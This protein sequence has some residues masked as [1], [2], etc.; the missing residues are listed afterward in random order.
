MGACRQRTT[1]WSSAGAR[2]RN[3]SVVFQ[4]GI[5]PLA[6]D[7][8]VTEYDV[9]VFDGTSTTLVMK[10]VNEATWMPSGEL[11]VAHPAT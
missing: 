1:S 5:Q 2:R 7:D 4:S 10:D 6:F 3:G 11:L 8:A 9:F